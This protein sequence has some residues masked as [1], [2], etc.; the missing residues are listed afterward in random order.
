VRSRSD[1]FF[2][3]Y[4][5]GRR[6]DCAGSGDHQQRPQDESPED[7]QRNAAEHQGGQRLPTRAA[8]VPARGWVSGRVAG[9]DVVHVY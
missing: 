1:H 8:Q 3:R 9:F 5:T 2:G 7:H 6:G 4:P